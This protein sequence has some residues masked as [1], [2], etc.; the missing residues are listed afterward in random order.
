MDKMERAHIL[1]SG[2][3]QGVAFR[4]YAQHRAQDL[5]LRGWVRNCWD[6]KVEILVEGEKEKIEELVKWC[7]Q[8]PPLAVVEEVTVEWQEYK[9]EYEKFN[10]R[11]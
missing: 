10:I 5:N 11:F 1:I 2:I 8:G 9:G 3:V 6:G 7:H 4:Y